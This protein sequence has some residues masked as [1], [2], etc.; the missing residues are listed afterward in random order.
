MQLRAQCRLVDAHQRAP[1][2]PDLLRQGHEVAVARDDHHRADVRVTGDVVRGVQAQADV[3]AVLGRGPRRKK[4][5]QLHRVLQ[6]HVPVAAEELPIAVGA[7]DG[8]GPKG[9]G[10]FHDGLHLD[11][12]FLGPKAPVGLAIGSF[13]Q[14]CL[15][16]AGVQV[17]KVPV[18]GNRRL[19]VA[20]RLVQ[21]ILPEVCLGTS[22][23]AGGEGGTRKTKARNQ[24]GPCSI[25]RSYSALM[26]RFESSRGQ[27]LENPK[28]HEYG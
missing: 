28:S 8:N 13:A 22:Q 5:D 3:R 15:R 24:S 16:K 19:G 27:V 6:Q 11:Q 25:C 14:A 21:G 20:Q 12:R 4:L 26:A 2:S 18:Q 7:V 17:F 10:Q 1:A 9:R 23:R